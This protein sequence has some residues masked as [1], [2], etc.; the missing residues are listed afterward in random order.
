[1]KNMFFRISGVF[2]L[3]LL[4][5]SLVFPPGQANAKS[6]RGSTTSTYLLQNEKYQPLG[7]VVAE[8]KKRR[9]RRT[10]PIKKKGI[11]KEATQKKISPQKDKPAKQSRRK[12]RRR[13]GTTP[14]AEPPSEKTEYQDETKVKT[15]EGVKVLEDRWRILYKENLIDPYNQNIVKGDR[16]ILGQDIFFTARADSITR[17]EFFGLVS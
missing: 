10:A 4:S 9:R 3:P 2:L 6:L 1:M 15:I 7:E 12:R 11:G 14:P 16:P 5:G 13:R 8:R 17:F